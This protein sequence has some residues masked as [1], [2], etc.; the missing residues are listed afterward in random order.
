MR[1]I[2]VNIIN[3]IIEIEINKKIIETTTDNYE[4]DIKAVG[5]SDENTTLLIT[6]IMKAL[7]NEISSFIFRY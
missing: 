2:K 5:L 7:R 1:L 3:D 4:T 6:H